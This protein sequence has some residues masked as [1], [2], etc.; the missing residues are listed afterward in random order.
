MGN[1]RDRARIGR[2]LLAL[3]G[4]RAREVG[5]LSAEDWQAV[6]ALA[7]QH[8]LRPFLHSQAGSGALSGVPDELATAWQAAQRANAIAMLAQRRALAQLAETLSIEGTAAVALKGSA[9]AWTVWPAPAQR[10]MRDIDVLVAEADA[11]LAYE[12]LRRSGWNASELSASALARF[13]QEETHFPPLYSAEG[14]MCELHAHVWAKPPLPGSTMPESDDPGV[15]SRAQTADGLGIAIP[16][17]EDMLAHLVVHAACS[18]LLNVGPMALVDI[19]LWCEKRSI[20]WDVFWTRAQKQGF[21]R[22]AALVF[23][24]TER[25]RWPGFLEESQCPIRIENDLLDHSELLLVQ[26]LDARKD[27][28]AIASLARGQLGGRMAQHPLDQAE[29]ETTSTGRLAQLAGR[30]ASLGK[31]VL[32]SRTRRDGLATAHLQDWLEG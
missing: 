27:V 25:W 32:S 11:P 13:A 20:D 23:A 7:D 5:A 3:C 12:A 19:A 29:K 8:R 10:V 28:S 21:A 15:L 2:A 18:H 26:D 14:V 1:E 9:L 31:S 17:N 24:L 4:H 22:A 6:D 30:A 16:S